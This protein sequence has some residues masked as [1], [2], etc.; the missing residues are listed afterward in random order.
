M[1]F[2][3]DSFQLIKPESVRSITR[4][5]VKTMTVNSRYEKILT[6]PAGIYEFVLTIQYSPVIKHIEIGK[7]CNALK[8]IFLMRDSSS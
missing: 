8:K 5:N 1:L 4:V 3:F 2:E 7:P 6:S